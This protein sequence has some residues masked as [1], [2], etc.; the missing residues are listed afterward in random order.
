MQL[1]GGRVAEHLVL[2]DI[3]TGAS[4]DIERAT[5]IVRKMVTQ[6]G[7]SDRLG[8][9]CLLYTSKLKDKQGNTLFI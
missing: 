1:L 6:Y 3:S 5:R 4:N 7:M 8:P 9:I 2:N